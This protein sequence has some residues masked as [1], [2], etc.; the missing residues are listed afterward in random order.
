MFS[1][2]ATTIDPFDRVAQ[3]GEAAML[4]KAET[5]AVQA[6][7]TQSQAPAQSESPF[8]PFCRID[9]HDLDE[10]CN[11]ALET[12]RLLCTESPTFGSE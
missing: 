11:D 7:P 3:H 10:A 6:T 12:I 5:L 9:D 1:L 4:R 8:K 2:S